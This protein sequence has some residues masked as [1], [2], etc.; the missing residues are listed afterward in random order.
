MAPLWF[1][2]GFRLMGAMAPDAAASVAHRLFFTPRRARVRAEERSALARGERFS[3][4]VAGRNVVARAWGEGPTVLLAHGWGGHAGQMT[5]LADAVVAAGYRAVAIDFTGHGESEGRLSSL[6]HFAWALE[7]AAALFKPLHGVVAHSLG[8]AAVTFAMSRGLRPARVVFFAP[9][10]EFETMWAYF[11]SQVGVSNA[12]WQKMQERAKG[13]IDMSFDEI[14]AVHLAPNMTA[15][16]LILHDA[17]DR[18]IP[19]EH[20]E[21]MVHVWSGAE[22]APGIQLVRTERLGHVRILHDA[23]AI[24][25]AVSFLRGAP[26]AVDTR[27]GRHHPA[28]GQGTEAAARPVTAT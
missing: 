12:V 6:V 28:F 5:S 25:A 10:T 26:A 23:H 27:A 1:R 16:L 22:S 9:A 7:R 14:Q 18:E 4:E 21:K 2:T 19:F 17:G 20:S 3:F 13:W 24:D 8:A 15:P 11:R